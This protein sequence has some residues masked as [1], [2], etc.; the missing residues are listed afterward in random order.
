MRRSDTHTA[1]VGG[2]CGGRVHIKLR[3]ELY[4]CCAFECVV[5]SSR[6]YL[7]TLSYV[8]LLLASD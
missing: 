6:L 2:V 7:S 1:L 8:L 4:S 5:L 3:S